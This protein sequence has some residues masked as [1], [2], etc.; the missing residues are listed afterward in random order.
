MGFLDPLVAKNVAEN[1]PTFL[2]EFFL[3]RWSREGYATPL[4]FQAAI[5]ST[6]VSAAML[7]THP[8]VY[9]TGKSFYRYAPSIPMRSP[10][11]L[12]TPDCGHCGAGSLVWTFKFYPKQNPST[13]TYKCQH[14]QRSTTMKR[15]EKIE[16]RNHSMWQV[17]WDSYVQWNTDAEHAVWHLNPPP[18][19]PAHSG[20]QTLAEFA[21]RYLGNQS[22]FAR[23]SFVAINPTLPLERMGAMFEL[24]SLAPQHWPEAAIF[25]SS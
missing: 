6:F 16:S 9:A 8:L 14:C 22:E 4:A 2:R 11:S 7:S 13:V 25:F 12:R 3:R 20:C 18:D 23:R 10:W 19:G 24:M 21:K 5:E 1:I 17:P 15:P